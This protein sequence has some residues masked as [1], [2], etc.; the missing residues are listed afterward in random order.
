MG[1]IGV[2]R[3]VAARIVSLVVS[4]VLPALRLVQQVLGFS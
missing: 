4:K 1:G 3:V 2:H